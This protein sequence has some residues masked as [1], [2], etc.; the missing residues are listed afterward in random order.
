MSQA[1]SYGIV[2]GDFNG[3]GKVDLA[4]GANGSTAGILLGNGN[5]TFKPVKTFAYPSFSATLV[6]AGDF[7]QDGRPDLA[8]G[9][10]QSIELLVQ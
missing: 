1:S 9:N 5:G 8:L 3:D 2:S 6:V 10:Y 7:N 4:V